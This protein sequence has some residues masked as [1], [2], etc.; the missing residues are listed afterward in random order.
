MLESYFISIARGYSNRVV[1]FLL[2]KLEG[3]QEKIRLA[4][5]DILKHLINS[6]S[7]YEVKFRRQFKC[8]IWQP[9]VIFLTV[10]H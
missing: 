7:E 6:C 5:L 4:T 10:D 9:K 2:Q 3:N 8:L 1:A